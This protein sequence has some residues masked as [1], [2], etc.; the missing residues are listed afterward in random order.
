M[1]TQGVRIAALALA[2]AACGDA[3]GG[4][5]TTDAAADVAADAVADVDATSDDGG[6]D[7]S[8]DVADASPP[9]FTPLDCAIVDDAPETF[10]IGDWAV[11][12]G[13]DGAWSVTAPT[14]ATTLRGLPTCVET[15]EDPVY[16]LRVGTGTP[17]YN[18][19][20]GTFD[21][22]IVRDRD[23]TIDNPP[24]IEW[25]APTSNA[26]VASRPE[27]VALEWTFGEDVVALE[28]LRRDEDHL[29]VTVNAP[30]FEAHELLWQASEG[31]AFFGLGTQ[32][33]GMDL[34]GGTFPLWTQEQGI[35][36]SRGRY[37]P[38][39]ENRIEAAYAPMGVWHSTA[40]Y[41]AIVDQDGFQELDLAETH[42]ERVALRTYPL[43]PAFVLV[44]G[45]TPRERL[46][47]ITGYTGRQQP[48]PDWAFGPWNDIVGG[49]N[50]VR[51]LA[52]LLRERDIPSSAIW[53]ED[54]I[55][56]ADTLN[57]YRLSYAW[58]WDQDTYPDLPDLIDELHASGF[59]FL[60]YFNPFVPDTNR[61]WD[62]G[63]EGDWLINDANGD[64]ISFPDPA[65]RNAS[66]VD[67]TDPGAVE[68]VSS[69]IETAAG[70]L[71]I[72]GWMADFAEWY[73]VN[74]V[75]EDGTDPWVLH[76]RYPLLWQQ[77]HRAVMER[78]HTGDD[79]NNWVF[80]ARSGWASTNGGTA[81][82]APIMWGGD[83]NTSWD[84]DDGYATVVPIAVHAG[85]AGVG[86]F[87]TDIA[88]YASVVSAPTDKELFYR[89]AMVGAFHP[90][91]RTHQGAEKC[92]NWQFPRDEET[93]L[94]YRRWAHVHTLLLPVWRSLTAEASGNGWPVMR[95]PWLV[96]PDRPAL[97]QQDGPAYFVGDDLF[98]A[99]VWIEGATS[100]EVVLPGAGWWPLF[101]DAPR[102]ESAGGDG[103][104]TVVAEAPATEIP[105]F[106]RPGTALPLL[107][108]APDTTFGDDSDE[109]T[110]VRELGDVIRWALYPDADGTIVSEAW[111]GLG[112]R[113]VAAVLLDSWDTSSVSIDG[114]ALG[115]CD[116]GPPCVDEA[117]GVVRVLGNVTVAVG[118]A[119]LAITAP[120]GAETQL[121]LAGSAWG[122]WTEPT[123]LTDL[124][125]D[126]PGPCDA[127]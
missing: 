108:E 17:G 72:D 92:D 29:S 52:A 21:I 114:V 87:A 63:L 98:V 110:D 122:E 53:S 125:P 6:E 71:G 67:L 16:G 33:F 123:P 61:M 80:F 104:T 49:S 73:P 76:N 116:D 105:V 24:E 120:E 11:T 35:G 109:V 28:F 59:A 97:W 8:A 30:A 74:A 94:H 83:Q 107:P 102:P 86:L 20:A 13:N 15:S 48:V 1:R 127:D 84:A 43:P 31:E 22:E 39:I 121:A 57:G 79:A 89:W 91:M 41:S 75:P 82:V 46:T 40:G 93:L 69:Y 70:D 62:E 65:F 111:T 118:S 81:G 112:D 95:H 23:D 5:E 100:R 77:T 68:W 47:A 103:T 7:G 32:V 14:G 45:D 115:S 44:A 4:D 36:K 27:G 2:L 12:L 66:L 3:G 50:K 85:L 42:E 60:G 9:D 64:A 51:D 106:V 101:G 117:D 26:R 96:E 78:V 88:G 55:G 56:G 119:E 10:A 19:N 25:A 54:W 18:L 126:V 113:S 99:P 90:V 58:E 38:I 124:D 34:R 37:I